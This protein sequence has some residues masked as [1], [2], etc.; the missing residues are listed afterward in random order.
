MLSGWDTR[1]WMDIR[2]VAVADYVTFER[3]N[4]IIQSMSEVNKRQIK[5]SNTVF[6]SKLTHAA[7]SPPTGT[8]YST[9]I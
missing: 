8:S 2:V 9:F 7:H 4:S 1:L 5:G 6:D 3:H